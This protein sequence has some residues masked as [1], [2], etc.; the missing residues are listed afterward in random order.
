V[1]G[2]SKKKAQPE[3]VDTVSPKYKT[4]SFAI[5][6]TTGQ[7][8]AAI[9]TPQQKRLYGLSMKGEASNLAASLDEE[10][11]LRIHLTDFQKDIYEVAR[12]YRTQGKRK[13]EEKK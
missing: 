7:V 13:V 12:A 5:Y 8:A 3:K 4:F 10:Q 6:L 11:V 2:V 9:L 1:E